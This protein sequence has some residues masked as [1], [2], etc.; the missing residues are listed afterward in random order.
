M[1]AAEAAAEQVASRP[2]GRVLAAQAT[3]SVL[4]LA[5]VVWWAGRQDLPAL[6]SPAE[7]AGPLAGALA[8]YALATALRGERWHWVLRLGGVP[9][10]RA[11]AYALT[12]VGYMGNNALPARAG[13]V[14]KSVLSARRAS[15]LRRDALGALVAERLLDIAA[16]GALFA[17]LVVAGGLPL[18]LPG[19]T[20]ALVA[21]G[22]A[23]GVLAVAALAPR[24]RGIVAS[25]L[26]PSR[27]LAGARGAALLGLSMLV[28]LA[29]GGVYALLGGVAGLDLTLADGLY[30]MAIANIAAMIPAA[31]GYVGT[32]DAAVL[33]GVRLIGG[34]AAGAAVAYVVLVRFV[35]FVPIAVVGLVLLVLR[36][37]GMATLRALRP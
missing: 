8:L 32:Y 33:L 20:L 5:V 24:V 27:R 6:P 12:T 14:I 18:G 13:D 9:A 22:A 36:Y 30:V 37:G 11:D 26:A 10:S 15:A 19:R 21:A 16:L 31:P 17:G 2:G 34:G 4:A 7:A 1:A 3:L 23:V 28:W 35:L 25:L 29:E